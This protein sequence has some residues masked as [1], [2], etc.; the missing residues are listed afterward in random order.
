MFQETFAEDS[1][2]IRREDGELLG[3]VVHQAEGWLP[4][5]A[6]GAAL[7]GPADYEQAVATVRSIGLS[8]LAEPWLVRS[9][10]SQEW[11]EAQLMEVTPSR[12]R[13][14]WKDPM[15]DQPPSGLWL[16]VDEIE[17]TRPEG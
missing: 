15:A 6:F 16:E 17:I 14:R 9:V 2:D 12:L 7:G 3:R 11:V 1:E 5:T 8:S 13:I 10:G 4:A